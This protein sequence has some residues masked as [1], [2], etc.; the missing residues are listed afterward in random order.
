MRVGLLYE[1]IK[2]PW[3][4]VNT[5][6]RNFSIH[7]ERSNEVELTRNCV[8]ADLILS[9]GH[10]YGPG[11][12]L[13]SYH[14]RNVSQGRSMRNPCGLLSKRGPKKIVFRVD[15]IRQIY[16]QQS[17]KADK[18]L[19]NNLYLA[20]SVV[21]Q[22]RFSKECFDHL[23]IP[24]PESNH[25]IL[26]GTNTD[27]FY[28]AW[29]FPDFRQGTVL[30]S[31]SWSTNLKKGF[32][33]IARFSELEGVTVLHIGRWPEG[34]STKAVKLLG[35]MGENQIAQILRKGHF[36]LFPSEDEA[37]PNTVV[38]ALASGVPV[39][40]D[41]SGGTPEICRHGLF[42]MAIPASSIDTRGLQSFMQV[43]LEKY[44]QMRDSI[45]E[46]LHAF[47]FAYC[48]NQY[49]HHFKRVLS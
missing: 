33:V 39:L 34:I 5:F 29:E 17:T 43:A 13:K 42:G 30:I 26:N 16:A 31:N 24:Y 18:I 2:E 32:E 14:L 8:D 40:Y 25:I 38:E 28:P 27:I 21:F 36:F 45:M 44:L 4:G 22:S 15:G 46:H 20:D 35:L 23:R 47:S 1:S 10:Y 7:A 48:F 3:G 11:R 9:A 6:F 49:I 19:I 37:C 12:L 41:D